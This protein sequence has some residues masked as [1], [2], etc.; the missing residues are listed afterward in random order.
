MGSGVTLE[1]EG[2][3]GKSMIDESIKAGIKHF[4]YS[5]VERGGNERSWEILT[6]VPH[7]KTKHEVEHHLRDLLRVSSALICSEDLQRGDSDLP[8]FPRCSAR[9]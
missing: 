4:V 9:P 3:Q 8:S 7:F 6:P 2:R 1:G 5:S